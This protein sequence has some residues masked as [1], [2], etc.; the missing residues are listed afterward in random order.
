M[1]MTGF[2]DEYNSILADDPDA[3]WGFL[4][5]G[6]KC[7]GL[8]PYSF[9]HGDC[10]IFAQYL[11]DTYGYGVEAV[12]QEPSQLVHCYCVACTSDNTA[13]YIDVRGACSDYT[14]FMREYYEA[15]LW[16]NDDYS[17]TLSY[18]E[19]PEKYC[20]PTWGFAYEAAEAIDKEY[21][22]YRVTDI[23]AVA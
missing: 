15:G 6:L 10:T 3:D 21:G 20:A 11:H 8:T 16:D 5:N 14:E 13:L 12:F 9:L 18:D 2:W 19:V 4:E 22:F 17:Y 1:R 7:R 23:R